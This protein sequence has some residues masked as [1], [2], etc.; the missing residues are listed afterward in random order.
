MTSIPFASQSFTSAQP[1]GAGRAVQALATLI[2][3]LGASLRRTV[4]ETRP[5]GAHAEAES[6]REL[7][8]QYEATDPGFA[9][10]LY[11]AADRH[12]AALRA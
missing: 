3:R 7:A 6:L 8:S 2:T 5:V 10:D 4:T 12:E 11:A 9:A 1:L